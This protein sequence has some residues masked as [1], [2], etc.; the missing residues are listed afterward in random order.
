MKIVNQAIK[1][2]N[3]VYLISY[4]EAIIP[5]KQYILL[6]ELVKSFD[7]GTKFGTSSRKTPYGLEFSNSSLLIIPIN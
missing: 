6:R 3:K 4:F 5:E 2:T 1:K 7:E